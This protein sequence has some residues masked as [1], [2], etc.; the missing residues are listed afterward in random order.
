MVDKITQLAL[1]S[2]LVHSLD[3]SLTLCPQELL[4][5]LIL[6]VLTWIV[7]EI[8]SKLVEPP[9]LAFQ[10]QHLEPFDIIS[11]PPIYLRV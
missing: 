10:G 8:D 3:N 4:R 1:P 5:L 2:L 6:A 7:L 9:L 11:L